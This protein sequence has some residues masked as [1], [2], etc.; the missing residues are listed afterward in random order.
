LIKDGI[1]KLESAGVERIIALPLFVASG[2][3]H[4]DEI[5]CLL[6]IQDC[7]RIAGPLARIETSAEIVCCSA[8][9]D[10]P[11]VVDILL[12]RAQELSIDPREETV[13]LVGH[14]ADE[15]ENRAKWEAVLQKLAGSLRKRGGFK[16]VTYATLHPDNLEKRAQAATRAN[17]TLVVPLFLSEGYFTK[18]VIPSR[19]QGLDYIY[20][21]KTYLPHPLVT[22]WM[23]DVVKRELERESA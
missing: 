16:E 5:G 9:D 15:G 10:H 3:T 6:G 14:G 11:F 23:E 12:E 13:M 19:L 18:T 20:S 2:S 8:M 22:S 7:K 1:E 17:R 4:L 21:G